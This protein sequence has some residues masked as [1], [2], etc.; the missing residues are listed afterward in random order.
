MLKNQGYFQC[1]FKYRLKKKDR[2]S[3]KIKC[4]NISG[5]HI[6][7]FWNAAIEINHVALA[8]FS[9]SVAEKCCQVLATLIVE[10][11]II[12]ISL[13]SLSSQYR[14][15]IWEEVHSFLRSSYVVPLILSQ[16]LVQAS[17]TQREERLRKKYDGGRAGFMRGE[18]ERGKKTT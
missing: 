17:P 18:V 16:Q 2:F 10:R 12:C 15:D 13:S 5:L 1:C 4:K 14:A 7:Y 11:K 6:L 8:N 3:Y 9:E